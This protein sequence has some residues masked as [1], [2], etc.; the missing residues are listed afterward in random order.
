MWAARMDLSPDRL[1]KA[2]K[3]SGRQTPVSFGRVHLIGLGSR[4][5]VFRAIDDPHTFGTELSRHP[6]V[7]KVFGSNRGLPSVECCAILCV[8]SDT[9]LRTFR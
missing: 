8:E 3:R 9:W 7:S 6:V 5:Y 4:N 1:G 2:K